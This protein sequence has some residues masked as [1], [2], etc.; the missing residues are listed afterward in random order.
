MSEWFVL[1][2]VCLFIYDECFNV[3]LCIV[4]GVCGLCGYD[5]DLFFVNY[6]NC[7]W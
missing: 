2:G 5:W 6:M 4:L 7:V 1:C 3:L